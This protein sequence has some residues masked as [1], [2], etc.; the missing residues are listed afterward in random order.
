MKH[1]RAGVL[2]LIA[3]LLSPEAAFCWGGRAHS[4]ID[5]TA[6]DTLPSDG[7]VSSNGFGFTYA[8]GPGLSRV[9]RKQPSA[10][11]RPSESNGSDESKLQ[12]ADGLRS[13]DRFSVGDSL[14]EPLRNRYR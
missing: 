9:A 12:P 10:K 8:A 13:C 3:T 5:R 4:V 1:S 2:L 14:G 7:P 11:Q 6:V